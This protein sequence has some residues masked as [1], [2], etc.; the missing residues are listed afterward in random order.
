MQTF[1]SHIARES[2]VWIA[3]VTDRMIH[4]NGGRSLGPYPDAMPEK[5]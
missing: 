3:E 1:V 2:S 4:F 5:I